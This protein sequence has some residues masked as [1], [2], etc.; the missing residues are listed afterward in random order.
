[1]TCSTPLLTPQS[2]E[3]SLS[4][5]F[6]WSFAAVDSAS[7]FT[8]VGLNIQGLLGSCT[9]KFSTHAGTNAKL[10]YLRFIRAAQDAP[11][12]ICLTET[13][14]SGKIDDADISIPGYMVQ[15]KDRDRR[16]G[17]VAIYYREN[18]DVTLLDLS[19]TPCSSLE[20]AAIKVTCR[21]KTSIFVC[22]YCK[23][24]S[25]VDWYNHFNDC[26]DYLQTLNLPIVIAGD[27]NINLKSD[28]SF[29]D[30]IKVT[31]GLKQLI[32]EPTRI[33]QKSATLIDHIYTHVTFKVTMQAHSICIYQTTWQFIVNWETLVR[34]P[35]ALLVAIRPPRIEARRT[36]IKRA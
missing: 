31:H 23:L 18:L 5:D 17:G 24:S 35:E 15:R 32:R 16:G 8:L 10:D 28:H 30:E 34:H 9:G 1:M 14:L 13:K 26:V 3:G 6:T 11:E 33:T 7:Y 4:G 21:L 2:P 12:I 27:F 20:C 25:K 19:S 29:A 36:Q 22:V